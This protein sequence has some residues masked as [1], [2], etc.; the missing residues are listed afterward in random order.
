MANLKRTILKR[1]TLKKDKH[2]KHDTF[3]NDPAEKRQFQKGTIWKMTLMNR[4][5]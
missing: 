2:L 3:Q 1:E 4:K 5:I